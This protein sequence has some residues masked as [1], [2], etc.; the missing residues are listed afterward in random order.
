MIVV[1][2]IKQDR[3]SSHQLCRSSPLGGASTLSGALRTRTLLVRS[4]LAVVVPGLREVDYLARNGGS[5]L[6]DGKEHWNTLILSLPTLPY[7]CTFPTLQ[8]ILL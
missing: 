2:N 1:I 5:L 6:L 8:V 3:G 4:S 7:V